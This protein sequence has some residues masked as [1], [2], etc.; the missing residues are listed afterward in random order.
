MK[1]AH[2]SHIL[3]QPACYRHMRGLSLVEIM[4]TVAIGLIITLGVVG[5]VGVNQQNLRIT[6]GLSESQE[7]ARMAFELI[8]RDVRQ[9]RDTSCGPVPS[10]QVTDL[11]SSWWENWNPIVGFPATTATSAVSTGAAKEQRV[12][13]TGALQLQGTTDAFLINSIAA[14]N[15]KATLS[16]STHTLTNG[17]IVIC[18][19][20][21]A[22]LHNVTASAGAEITIA[23]NVAVTDPDNPQF[24]AA[25]YTAVTW[26]IGNNGRADEGGRS[27]YRI[28]RTPNGT[29][30]TEEILPGVVDM[31]IRYH[32]RGQA[33]FETTPPA[34]EET[35]D[36]V[37]AIE[38]TL[39]TETTQAKVTTD[40]A[41]A[42]SELVGTDGRLRRTLTHVIALRNTL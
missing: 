37:N 25:R 19:L 8:A 10:A 6:E 24:Q 39:I 13:N 12:N 36:T 9:A 5:V 3:A 7:N 2:P 30:V 14:A 38:L 26:Y 4:V 35:W 31:V 32:R 20:E 18:D 42:D 21:N 40:S 27:L 41:S 17:P 33:A 29:T 15:N 1:F 28:R 11:G 23:P 34:D 22:S 16:S